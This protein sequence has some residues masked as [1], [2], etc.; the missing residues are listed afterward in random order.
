MKRIDGVGAR[1]NV[2]GLG[3][4][5][6][7]DNADLSN[8]DA[9]HLTPDWLN[10]VQEELANVIEGFGETL[11]PAQKNQVYMVVKGINDRTTAIENF[12]ENIVDFFLP[13][14]TIISSF[15]PN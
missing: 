9:T 5:G 3:K 8:Q 2:N 10:T 15:D 4:T 1:P 7:H 12:I 11:N 14:N 6:F 13:I